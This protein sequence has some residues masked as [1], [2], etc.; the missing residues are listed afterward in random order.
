MD[1]LYGT[2]ERSITKKL[3]P[4]T[5]PDN[6]LAGFIHCHTAFGYPKQYRLCPDELQRETAELGADFVFCAGDHDCYIDD[7]YCSAWYAGRDYYEL[8]LSAN[9]QGKVVLIPTGE[10]HLWFEDMISRDTQTAFWKVKREHPEYKPFHHTLI[11]MINWQEAPVRYVRENTS[12]KLLETSQ[13][14]GI[15]PTLNHPGLCHLNGHPDPLNIPWFRQMP[16]I[17]LFNTMDYFDYDWAIYKY[18]LSSSP[19]SMRMAVFAGVDLS[20]NKNQKLSKIN[21]ERLE[22]ITY[23]YAPKGRTVE[24]IYD[25]WT[26]RRTIA[27]RGRLMLEQISHPPQLKAYKTTAL[28]E[29]DFRICS[30]DGKHI[31][32]IEILRNGISA[33][34]EFVCKERVIE[35]H[36]VDEQFDGQETRYTIAI[37][38]EGD[39][40]ITS[41]I[42]FKA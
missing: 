42:G 39:W 13:A 31:R 11:P 28:P 36:W 5:L 41:T 23:I 14:L 3:F 16:Y 2:M 34:C 40:L 19:D 38:A 30:F 8:T 20:F 21:D 35:R 26:Q 24:G 17:E 1:K 29:L 25:A 7:I 18:Y 22:H 27:V 33:Y 6:W 12:A 9:K 10:Y 4:S 15:S 32:K 37:E